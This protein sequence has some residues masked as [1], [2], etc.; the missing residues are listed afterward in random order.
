MAARGVDLSPVMVKKVSERWADTGAEF[1]CAEVLDFLRE[2]T[3]TYDAVYSNFGAAW[4]TD[5]SRLFPLVRGRLR[6]G[7]LFVFSQP[8]AI[9]GAYGP[10][11][12]QG[13]L[14]R[15]GDVR[16]PLQLPAAVWERLLLG[17]GSA[18]RRRG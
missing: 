6:P 14:R 1:V 9:P 10:Q 3:Q 4:F 15:Q 13:R 5:P 7:G 11:A 17:P 18:W 8:P 12:C 2:D 16:L